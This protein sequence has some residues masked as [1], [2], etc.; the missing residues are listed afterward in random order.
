[1]DEKTAKAE[2]EQERQLR[3]HRWVWNH[4]A[5][6]VRLLVR[7]RHGGDVIPEPAPSLDGPYQ[8]GRAHV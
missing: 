2:R 5:P 6:L 8:I 1:M 7:L 4:L 3:R